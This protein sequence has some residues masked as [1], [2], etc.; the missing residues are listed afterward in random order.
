M[1]SLWSI[2]SVL[3][4]LPLE[5]KSPYIKAPGSRSL[6]SLIA[7]DTRFTVGICLEAGEAHELL[8]GPR[9]RQVE[10]ETLRFFPRDPGIRYI[11][12]QLGDLPGWV[13]DRRDRL[14]N[15]WEHTAAEIQRCDLVICSSSGVMHLAGAMGKPV[16]ALI[17]LRSP[18][19]HGIAEEICPWY[20]SVRQFR[21]KEPF[22][23]SD[24]MKRIAEEL[25]Q[26]IQTPARP[27]GRTGAM[28]GATL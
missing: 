21:A 9:A 18:W 16:W 6:R 19:T 25:R 26:T 15:G 22:N 1:V 12:L 4:Q 28:V 8:R 20:P 11:G 7:L 13:E 2:P 14:V 5:M 17:P 23:Y 3:R 10:A 24:P 27:G